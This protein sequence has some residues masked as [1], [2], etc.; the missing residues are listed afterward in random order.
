MIKALLG[1]RPITRV[2]LKHLLQEVLAFV[3]DT[4]HVHANRS[5]RILVFVGQE[6]FLGGSPLE[7]VLAA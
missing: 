3:A 1:I 2:C 5:E 6:H 4:V 7:H